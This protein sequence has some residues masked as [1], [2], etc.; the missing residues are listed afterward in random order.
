MPPVP[1]KPK[2]AKKRGPIDYLAFTQ[3]G[4]R[5]FL[6]FD[7]QAANVYALRKLLVEKMG[8][9]IALVI[10]PK[11]LAHI[12]GHERTV[13]VKDAFEPGPELV[14]T[15]P[16]EAPVHAAEHLPNE[17]GLP[18]VA[19]E[20][21]E[22]IDPAAAAMAARAAAAAQAAEEAA[23][24]GQVPPID[25]DDDEDGHDPDR[26]PATGLSRRTAAEARPEDEGR[27]VFPVDE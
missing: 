13:I 4:N 18:L 25:P 26:D 19:P 6:V 16:W 27:T 8:A 21:L 3:I 9:G 10:I 14:V 24:S 15:N 1:A 22:P 20:E 11:G 7:D 17:G 5:W 23:R 2:T 12:V